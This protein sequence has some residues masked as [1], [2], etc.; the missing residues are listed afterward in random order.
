MR[1]VARHRAHRIL[2]R[3]SA[4]PDH[5]GADERLRL[6][7]PANHEHAIREPIEVHR[8]AREAREDVRVPVAEHGEKPAHLE[9]DPV[10]AQRRDALAERSYGREERVGERLALEAHVQPLRFGHQV[11]EVRSPGGVPVELARPQPRHARESWIAAQRQEGRVLLDPRPV[12]EAVLERALEPREGTVPGA[13]LPERPR[14]A[15]LEGGRWRGQ[16][17]E[18]AL[19]RVTCVGG[20]SGSLEQRRVLAPQPRIGRC[21]A[22]QAGKGRERGA[23]IPPLGGRARGAEQPVVLGAGE[24]C[25]RR[26]WCIAPPDRLGDADAGAGEPEDEG[27]HPG[28]AGDATNAQCHEPLRSSCRWSK[29]DGDRRIECQ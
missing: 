8:K 21:V 22:R 11:V 27:E 14:D 5:L 13:F 7:A 25:A 19:E 3:Q 20:P 23:G 1:H 10:V 29:G 15:V 16:R 24:R 28:P 9:G 26:R 17:A 4:D 12:L 18:R 6:T 2:R